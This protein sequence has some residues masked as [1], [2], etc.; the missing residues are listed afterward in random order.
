MVSNLIDPGRHGL[1]R[2]Q[3]FAVPEHPSLYHFQES[4]H[5]PY[6][7]RRSAVVREQGHPYDASQL[8]IHGRS[9]R[10]NNRHRNDF[11][12]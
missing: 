6:C 11:I 8:C 12:L 10:K 4:D 9:W 5:Y 2:K 7:L 3:E 1:H